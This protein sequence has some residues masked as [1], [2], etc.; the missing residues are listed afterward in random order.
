MQANRASL[1]QEKM[2][3]HVSARAASSAARCT[4][5]SRDCLLVAMRIFPP[6]IEIGEDEGFTPEKD[7]FKRAAF[8]EGLTNLVNVA[9]DP[10]VI[11]LD[12]PWGTGKTTF[13]KMWAGHLRK[14]GFPVIY[15]DA[16]KND[17]VDDGFLAIA[18]EV[19][20]LS[21]SLKKT[22][23]AAHKT[24]L[25]KA[26]RAGGILL[27]TSAKIGVKAATL[28][29]IDAADLGALKSVADDI[30]KEA[31]TTADN[32]IENI[33]KLQSQ[34]HETI[35]NLRDSLSELAKSFDTIANAKNGDERSKPLI[36]IIDELDRCKPSFALEL[37]EKIK[38]VFSIPN[39]HFLLAT[40]L[41]QL[42]TS[43]R[44]SYG[45]DIDARNYLQKFYN[46]IVHFPEHGRHRHERSIPKYIGYIAPQLSISPDN[47]LL[48]QHVAEARHL[49][50]RSIERIATCVALA[51]Q[52]TPQNYLWL[53]PIVAGLSILKVLDVELFR[54]ARTGD[55]SFEELKES[56]AI[57]KWL[58]DSSRRE[59]VQNWWI[60]CLANDE[61]DFP[62]FDWQGFGQRLWQ[63]SIGERKDIVQLMAEHIDR[64]QLPK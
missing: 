59:W 11:M 64:F 22:K 45:H 42:E 6:A 29:A 21:Q 24:F 27:R 15:F 33:L 17:H 7:I 58:S 39:V 35:S 48:V 52:F 50:L 38:H 47:L 30:A 53:D 1:N 28:G 14:N 41:H 13:I 19:I 54:K 51:R 3:D 9:D 12:S 60:Y 32:Y 44:F 63:Y 61:K 8:G 18:A 4:K 55:L 34:E 5:Q 23:T 37:L 26:A 40:H 46:V 20:R 56:L 16:F 36:F 10:L 43:V 25:K 57:D 49:S 31:S 62:D 2:W